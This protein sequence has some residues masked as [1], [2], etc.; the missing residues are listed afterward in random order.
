MALNELQ[1]ELGAVNAMLRSISSSQVDR[2]DG[3]DIPVDAAAA[4]DVLREVSRSLQDSP[5]GWTWNTEVFNLPP[6]NLTGFVN[7]PLNTLQAFPG[8]N[9]YVNRGGR[10]YDTTDH[11]FVISATVQTVVRLLLPFDQMPNAAREYVARKAKRLFQADEQGDAATI[12]QPDQDELRAFAAVLNDNAEAVQ[13]N[14]T[15]GWRSVRYG[16]GYGDIGIR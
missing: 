11:T 15:A 4:Y 3:P 9:R 10:L 6:E 7:L 12:R 13:A 1:T 5:E 2:L 14:V 8:D 16:S